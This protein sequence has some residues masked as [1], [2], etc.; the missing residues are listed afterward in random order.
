[1]VEARSLSRFTDASRQAEHYR[2]GRVLLAGDAAHIQ[3]PAG[4]P[5]LSTGLSDAV[6]LGWKLAAHIKSWAP[7]DLLDTYHT[8]RHAAGKR[9]L[10]HTRA[11]GA[12]LGLRRA[13]TGAARAVRRVDARPFDGS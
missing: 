1:M 4:G 7:V 13:D 2:R 11:Q 5:G 8:E 10:M 12:L 3:L 9:M 6:N